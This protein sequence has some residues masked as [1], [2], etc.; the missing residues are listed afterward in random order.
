MEVNY[1][2]SFS[3]LDRINFK[4]LIHNSIEL[5]F[6]KKEIEKLDHLRNL[7]TQK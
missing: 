7:L 2:K 5:G 4:I 6:I 1:I 3:I